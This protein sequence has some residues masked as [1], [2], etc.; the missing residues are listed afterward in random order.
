MELQVLASKI[1]HIKMR[2][3]QIGMEVLKLL[4][5]WTVTVSVENLK[6]M[7]KQ[8]ELTR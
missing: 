1:T 6:S 8:I 2:Y 7:K 4:H 5:S 3:T